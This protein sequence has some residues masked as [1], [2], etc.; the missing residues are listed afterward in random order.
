MKILR[1]GS[2]ADHGQKSIDLK[3]PDVKW[4]ARNESIVF[5]KRSVVNF[6]GASKHD[7]EVSLS[8]KEIG[9]ILSVVGEKPVEESPKAISSTLSIY[10]RQ[11]L[12]LVSTCV[13]REG[14]LDNGS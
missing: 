9:L 11:L 12:R 13:G 7:Y 6:S 4:D 14:L 1:R 10:L 3:S 8:L 5:R 2:T